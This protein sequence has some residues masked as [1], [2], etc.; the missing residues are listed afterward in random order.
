MLN[1]IKNFKKTHVIIANLIITLLILLSATVVCFILYN[2]SPGNTSNISLIIYM[3][4]VFFIA[5]YTEGYSSGI[6]ASLISVVCVNFLFTYP[7]MELNFTLTGYPLTFLGTFTI[8]LITSAMTTNMKQQ[9]YALAE[10]EKM[11]HEAEKEKMRA[12]LLR[13]VSHDLRTP[14]TGIIGA[15]TSILDENINM[16][17][18]EELELISNISSDANWLLHM[19]ENLLS[20]T[21]IQEDIENIHL[22]PEPIEE[23]VGEAI[24][25]L[26]KRYP[27]AEIKVTL[28]DEFI[29]IPVDAMLI[30]QVIINLLENA[31][32]HSGSAKPVEC[33]SES[34]DSYITIYIK[35]YGVGLKPESIPTIFDANSSNSERPDSRKGMG[36]GLSICRTIIKA[37]GGNIYA[38]NHEQ[39]A[40]F[41][42]TLLKEDGNEH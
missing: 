8:A 6:I 26:K 36:I 41:Y 29:M 12:T 27:D 33:Y 21:R 11:L 24:H 10:H 18:K 28:P 17:R 7:F 32:I 3:L 1:R 2:I 13:A 20:V 14:L 37:H 40:L 16:S 38:T 9:A 35:D 23:V 30:E 39:G 4:S 42:F 15:S 22:T 19:V 5:R 31:L 25:R 34:N